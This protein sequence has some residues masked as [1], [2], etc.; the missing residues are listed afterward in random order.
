MNFTTLTSDMQ[1]YLERGQSASTDPTV[2]AQIPR[3]INQAE[4]RIMNLLKLQGEIEVL[5]D[6]AG[7][8]AGVEVVTKPDRWRVT[9]SM[10]YGTSAGQNTH[11]PLFP[12]SYEYCRQYWGNGSATDSNNPPKW[13]ADYNLNA[14]LISPTPDQNYPL[15]VLAYMQPF[16]LDNVNQTN[17]FTDYT[18]ALLLYGAL[19]EASP[20]LKNDPRLATWQTLF[21]KEA[22]A[23]NG[24]DLQKILDRGEVRRTA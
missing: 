24:A 20:F 1:N 9:V 13:Y 16:L 7:L 5:V 4:R 18:P 3:L 23:I 10:N 12:R 8:V 21:D 22:S 17:F 15:E 11:T 19:I 2:F 6:P 14:W